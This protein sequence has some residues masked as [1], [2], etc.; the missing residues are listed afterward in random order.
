MEVPN[1]NSNV[2]EAGQENS[3]DERILIPLTPAVLMHL[4]EQN[5]LQDEYPE[6]GEFAKTKRFLGTSSSFEICNFDSKKEGCF[7]VIAEL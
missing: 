7:T 2:S 3:E 4:L 5:S 1:N 6:N